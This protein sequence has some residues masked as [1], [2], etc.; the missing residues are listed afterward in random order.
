MELGI[1]LSFVKTSELR[2]VGGLNPPNH[3]LGT[4]QVFSLWN[5]FKAP[6]THD[7]PLKLSE[8]ICIGIENM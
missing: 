1:R 5:V 4:P 8:N 2:G 3:P 6:P 7:K